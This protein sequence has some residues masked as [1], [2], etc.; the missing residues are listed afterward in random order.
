[1]SKFV[2]V[3]FILSCVFLSLS[4]ALADDPRYVITEPQFGK[5][6]GGGHL[7]MPCDLD[8][9]QTC[10]QKDFDQFRRIRGRCRGDT[11]FDMV[12]RFAGKKTSIGERFDIDKDGC[13]T[14]KDYQLWLREIVRQAANLKKARAP[15]VPECLE[16]N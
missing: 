1:M 7:E 11:E 15:V 9:D 2:I 4:I 6:R 3:V 10:S 8:G 16:Q 14:C 12:S 5:I 13:I